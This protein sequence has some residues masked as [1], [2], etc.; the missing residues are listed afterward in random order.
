MRPTRAPLSFLVG[1]LAAL[2]WAWL[3]FASYVDIVDRTFASTHLL[4]ARGELD[5]SLRFTVGELFMVPLFGIAMRDVWRS[6][7]SEHA[8]AAGG[9]AALPLAA[10]IA[11]IISAV[12]IGTGIEAAWG[13]DVDVASSVIPRATG[14]VYVWMFARTL[15]GR[16]HPAGIFV[17]AFALLHDLIGMLVFAPFVRAEMEPMWLGMVVLAMAVCEG[18]RRWNVRSFWP[19]VLFG[20]PLAWFGLTTAGLHGAFALVPIV[21]FMRRPIPEISTLEAFERFLTPVVELGLFVF[22]FANVGML[23]GTSLLTNAT[24]VVA[25]V[26]TF[27]GAVVGVFVAVTVGRVGGLRLPPGVDL[28]RA[29]VLGMFCGASFVGAALVDAVS[30]ADAA[31]VS[32]TGGHADPSAVR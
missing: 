18:F 12:L 6:S 2:V 11:A 16:A 25:I 14:V 23:V 29:L 22:A 26:A 7:Q 5:L 30:V 21:P 32:E 17:V 28:R 10:A 15:Y 24:V 20:A 9:P 19:Y 27:A 3:D 4:A 1:G 13:E 31:V 8:F